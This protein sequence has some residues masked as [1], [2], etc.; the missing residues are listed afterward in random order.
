M[1]GGPLGPSP[2][3][4]FAPPIPDDVVYVEPHPRRIEA[5]RDGQTVLD[6]E[7]AL[8][9]HRPG[10]TLTYELE[11]NHDLCLVPATGKL[12]VNGVPV[13]AGDGVAVTQETKVEFRALQDAELVVVELV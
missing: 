11:A 5:V 1:R 4:W 9:V 7:D 10:R 12:L 6:T 2:A 3:G 8:L 13:D